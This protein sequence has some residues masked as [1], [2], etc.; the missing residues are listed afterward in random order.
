VASGTSC[1]SPVRARGRRTGTRRPPSTT[2]P[3]SMPCRV[4]ARSGS[5]LPLGPHAAVISASNIARI[6]ANPAATLIANS[7]SRAAEATSA[8]ASC[9]SPGKS[10]TPNSAKASGFDTTRN[11][12]TVFTAVPFLR[13][14]WRITRDLPP[15]RTQAGDRHLKSHEDR[16][17]L[18]RGVRRQLHMNEGDVLDDRPGE[19]Q[20]ANLWEAGQEGKY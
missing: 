12:G 8:S 14:S 15:G 7:P 10:V 16:D 5:C 1:P 18:R 2:E 17:T 3:F 19:G 20:Q 11:V 6:T 9:T 13:C 4:A